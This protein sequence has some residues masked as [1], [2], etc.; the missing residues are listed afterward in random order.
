MC[1]TSHKSAILFLTATALILFAATVWVKWSPLLGR[2]MSD[3]VSASPASGTPP[4]TPVPAQAQVSPDKPEPGFHWSRIESTDYRRYMA[5]LRAI[6]CPERVL[7]DIIIGDVKRLFAPKEAPFKSQ[8]SVIQATPSSD[9]TTE[10]GSTRQEFGLR[11]QL[12]EIENEKQAVIKELLGIE[13]PLAPIRSWHPRTYDRYESAL[14][15]VPADKREPVRQI[16]ESYWETSD[17]LNDKYGLRRTPEY[18]EEY[19]RINTDRK[20]QLAQVLTPQ[21]LADYEMRSTGIASRLGTYL[22]GVL[23][24]ADEFGEVFQLKN[25]VEAPYGGS[26]RVDM[27]EAGVT[28]EI[29]QKRQE[30]EQKIAEIL[31]PERYKEYQLAQDSRFQA[32]SDLGERFGIDREKVI[33]AYELQSKTMDPRLMSRYGLQQTPQAAEFQKSQTAIKELLGEP[34]YNALQRGQNLQVVERLL[35]P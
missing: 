1:T 25:A 28:P 8:L 34:A 6:G 5:N 7:E 21:E 20:A 19:T 2:S 27:T 16:Q 4:A 29:Q 30:A 35:G 12:R 33:Q 17:Q 13:I 24:T 14:N 18:L 31:G 15:T 11:K 9:G 32:L 3:E 10:P 22:S 23:V 26:V